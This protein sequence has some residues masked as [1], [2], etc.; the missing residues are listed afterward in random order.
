MAGTLALTKAEL[1]RLMHNRRYFIFT[2]AFPADMDPKLLFPERRGTS[3][4]R[5]SASLTSA[6][7]M[8]PEGDRNQAGCSTPFGVTD[9][10]TRYGAPATPHS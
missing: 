8:L 5:L 6:Q 3:A 1:S 9:F 10:G 4:Q 2:V 7:E